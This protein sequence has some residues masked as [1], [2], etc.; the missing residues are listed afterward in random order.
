MDS[1]NIKETPNNHFIVAIGASAGGLEAIHEFFDNMPSNGNLSF[2]I[3]QHLSPDYK[4]LLVELIA[5]HTHMDVLEAD[6]MMEVKE[7]SVYV[8]PNNKL[9]TIHQGKLIL[10]EKSIEKAPNTAVDTLLRSLAIDQGSKAIAIIL[11]G[12]GTDGSKGIVEIHKKGGLIMVQDPLTAKF[13]GMP[14]S[15]IATGVADLILTPELMPEE[16]FN[17]INEKPQPLILDGKPTEEMLPEVMMLIEKNCQQDFTNYKTPTIIRRI[18]RRMGMLGYQDFEEYLK[19]LHNSA[20]ECKFLGK[21]FLIGVTKFFRDKAGFNAL[22]NDVLLPLIRKKQEGEVLKIWIVACSTGEEAYSI[23]ILIDELLQKEDKYLEVKI[24]ASDIDQEAIEYASR[25]TYEASNLLEIDPSLIERYFFRENDRYVV[26]SRIR[27]QIVFARHNVLK[28]PPFIKNDIVSCRN[29]LIYMNN[30]LQKKIITTFEFAL[31]TGGYL[32]LGPSESPVNINDGFKELNGKW[33]LYQKVTNDTRF[34]A[35]RL[36]S[37]QSLKTG[38]EMQFISTAREAVLLKDLTDDFRAVLTEK[39][40]FAALYIDKNFEI[41]EAIGDFRKYLSL[42]DRITSL[43]LM[44]MV[45]KDL[46]IS[47]NAAIR[48]SVRENTEVVLSNFKGGANTDKPINIFVRPSGSTNNVLVLLSESHE[49]P[50]IRHAHENIAIP[51]AGAASYIGELEEELKETRFNLQMAVESLETSNEELQSSNEELLSANE[52]L[53]SSNEELQSLNEELHTLNTEHQLRIRELVELNDDL[54]NYFS[55]TEIAQVFVDGDFR[56]RKFNPAAIKMIN[57]IESDIGRPIAHISTNI[58]DGNN[59]PEDIGNVIK[60][61]QPLEKE[62]QLI[63]GRTNLMRI[64]PYVRQ[65]N[66]V[67]G[68]VITF[69]D[70]T[71]VR[72]LNTIIHSVFNAT[73]SA[74]MAFRAVR[75]RQ[76]EIK[77]FEW[78]AANYASDELL[79]Q[80]NEMYMGKS[81]Q[82]VFPQVLKKGFFEKCIRV[83]NNGQSFQMEMQLDLKGETNWFDIIVTP[84]MDGI[85]ISLTNINEKKKSEEK[86]RNNYHELIKSKESYRSL[87]LAL[88]QKVK[89]RT[90]DLAQSE[91]RFRLIS[92]AISDAIWDRNLVTNSIWWSDSFYNWFGYQKGSETNTIDFWLN[93]IHPD[94][95]ERVSGA[96]SDAIR[97]AKDFHISYRLKNS[98]GLYILVSDKGTV[99]K[100]ESGRPYRVLGAITDRTAEDIARQNEVLKASNSELEEL[101][102]IRTA[103]VEAQKAILQN[104]FM[105]APAMICTLSGPNHIYT[106]VNPSYQRLFGKTSLVGKTFEETLLDDDGHKLLSLV[107]QVYRTGEP[108]IGK[109]VKLNIATEPGKKREDIYLNFIYQPTR[110]ENNKINGILI[111]AYEVTEQVK[112]RKAIQDANDELIKLNQEFKFVTDF[113]PQLVWVTLP[114]GNHIFF[115]N[116]WYEYTGLSESESMGKGWSK[117]LHPE[118]YQR[119]LKVWHTALETG[120]AYEIEYRFKRYDGEYRWF[121]ARALPM[122]DDNNVIVKW[123]GT[124]TDIHDQKIMNDVLEARVIERTEE[125]QSINTE[126]EAR[127]S[128]LLQ[129]ASI[130]SHDLKEPLRKITMFSNLVKDRH[131]QA[132]P[133]GAL[134]YVNKIIESSTRMAALVNDLLSFTKLTADSSFESINLNTVIAEVLSD[135]E[136]VIN[137]KNAIIEVDD[138][139]VADIVPGYMRQVFQNIISNSLKFSR[140]DRQPHIRISCTRVSELSFTNAYDKKGKFCRI[141]I[142][143]NGIGF[144]NEYAEKIFTIFQ[145]LHSRHEYEG[146]GIGLAIARKIIA[147]HKGIITAYSKEGEGASFVIVLPL[148][149]KV[150]I[151]ENAKLNY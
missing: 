91:E 12:T 110:D 116:G 131:S 134:Q 144:D 25:A 16:I 58:K 81:L 71:N 72:E 5:K 41:K 80:A 113:M 129:F 100:D 149:Q 78:I 18:T 93:A 123:F 19:L 50:H 119:A 60:N 10:G 114:D 1:L 143:D 15:A 132:L 137:E 9:L 140:D 95:K 135:L 87:N 40:G 29:M 59:F 65:D 101:V 6:H 52:E 109:E 14:N 147:K 11:S 8:I 36:P 97:R 130:A 146:T 51:E 67:D 57:L 104:L 42:P 70:I 46:S 111:F 145:R 20:D 56:I 75:N 55:S 63:N 141:T 35:E 3:I 126:L 24:F 138:M 125:L 128:E 62:V 112:A 4:S 98:D 26:H 39:Y 82:A 61:K 122:R 27:K 118:D 108:Y 84:M 107:E 86:L 136:L 31:N 121:L 102:Q 21:E 23:A 106:L 68:A 150:D 53:Q 73:Q 148:E 64:L 83:I 79:Q 120:D 28:D 89:E 142:K 99:L 33:K 44:K 48:K 90:H 7:N 77:D 133:T 127:N 66:N 32:F 37:A 124:C 34:N 115:N 45:G 13:D 88:E 117:V 49:L 30:I 96:I 103:D 54:N 17:Y 151:P 38:K 139:P 92:N 85:L 105:Q 22:Q 76:D 2:I 74:V 94:D 69:I 43:N 47:L